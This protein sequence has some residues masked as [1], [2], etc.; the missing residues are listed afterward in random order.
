MTPWNSGDL[1][2]ERSGPMAQTIR[3]D[4]HGRSNARRPDE[5][6]NPFLGEV[7]EQARSS[8]A[9]I[10]MHFETLEYLNSSTVAVLV[11]FL[12]RARAGNVPLCFSYRSSVRWQKLSFEALRVF[13][14]VDKRVRVVAVTE[15]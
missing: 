13:E 8:L 6:L 7:L 14:Q 10:E 2:I 3:L 5:A 12:H 9:E 11:Q 4:W 15:A 1:T